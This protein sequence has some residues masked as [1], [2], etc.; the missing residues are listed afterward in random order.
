MVDILIFLALKNKVA[1]TETIGASSINSSTP[2]ILI[3]NFFAV[4]FLAI[5]LLFIDI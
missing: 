5:L 2:I 1:P 3:Y 4:I